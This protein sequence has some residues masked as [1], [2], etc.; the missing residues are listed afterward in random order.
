MAPLLVCAELLDGRGRPAP[1]P[2]SGRVI[3][4]RGW[5]I[6]DLPALVPAGCLAWTIHPIRD[7]RLPGDPAT[8]GD[9]VGAVEAEGELAVEG[10]DPDSATILGET[11]VRLAP[12][13]HRIGLRLTAGDGR[14]LAANHLDVEVRP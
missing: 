11:E 6:N 5:L 8:A 1:R 12:G 2:R 13:W 4:L 7:P 14:E 9:P 10:V 3:Q